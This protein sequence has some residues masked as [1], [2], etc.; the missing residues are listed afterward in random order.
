[1]CCAADKLPTSFDKASAISGKSTHNCRMINLDSQFGQ[2]RRDDFCNPMK[3][4]NSK[5]QDFGK[6]IEVPRC[7][8]VSK[9]IQ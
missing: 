7:R 9:G 5:D 8:T 3:L 6:Q 2:T 1:M 4:F